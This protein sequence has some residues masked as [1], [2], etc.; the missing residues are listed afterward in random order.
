[1]ASPTIDVRPVLDEPL[2]EM[3]DGG[4]VLPGFKVRLSELFAVPGLPTK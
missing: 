4:N 1:M 2:Y 3:L